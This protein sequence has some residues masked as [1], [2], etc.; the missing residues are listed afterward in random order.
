MLRKISDFFTEKSIKTE[1]SENGNQSAKS[2][3][4]ISVKLETKENCSN[5][6][7]FSAEHQINSA[8][9]QSQIR[10]EKNVKTEV[11]K[12]LLVVLPQ[13]KI[14]K[15]PIPIKIEDSE[16]KT[17][18]ILCQ[19]C[20]KTFASLRY[21]KLHQKVHE[22]EHKC[23]YCEKIFRQ[24]CLML[25]HIR[26][27]HE[28]LGS[29]KCDVCKVGFNTKGNLT[30]HQRIHI[31]NR[32]KPFKC[33]KC[34]HATDS[35]PNFK[36]HLKTHERI[37]ER[38]EKCNIILIKNRTHDCRLDC[39]YCGKKFSH[40][41]SVIQH[42]KEHH[43]QETEIPFYECDICGLKLY[44]KNALRI[45]MEMKHADGKTQIFTCDLDGKTFSSKKKIG[46]HMKNHLPPVK[47]DFCHKKVSIRHLK[48]HI[49]NSHTGI[50]QPRKKSVTK[51]QSFEC[52]IC[53]TILSTKKYLNMH[54]SDHNKTIKCKFCEKMFGHR[55]NLKI[56]IRDYHENPKGHICN[57]CG[58]KFTQR[59][60]LRTHM[61]THDPNR[62][63]DLK[64]TQCDF[65][66]FD[67]KTFQTHLNFHKKKN[68]E[69]AAMENP[70]RCPKCP[71]VLKSK[72]SLN[73]H[74][75]IVHPKNLFECDICGR[76]IKVKINILGHLKNV[77][78]INC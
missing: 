66:T 51:K 54:V 2:E 30:K 71:S 60:H 14:H 63:R 74:M 69:I 39:K 10:I 33:D 42:I 1:S 6:S 41:V 50:K 20:K 62:A 34:D 73:K 23:K 8:S 76:M 58:K 59:S 75:R 45:H 77:H 32:P 22:I 3:A 56:H 21:L 12:Q 28:N 72:R 13:Q 61:K 48:G 67:K 15:H 25:T 17:K 47:C 19:I 40:S 44:L 7:E 31:K 46:V 55:S 52:P 24:N 38:C 35:K 9:N 4:L 5:S 57:I 53:F 70:H 37:I 78:K 64:C 29:Y 65:A 68:A 16:P 36:R 26:N 11:E 18:N 27:F 43:A 49:L